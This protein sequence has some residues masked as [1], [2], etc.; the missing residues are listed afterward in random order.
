MD[1]EKAESQGDL[2]EFCK[3]YIQFKNM[4]GVGE[5]VKQTL[6][7]IFLSKIVV[8]LQNLIEHSSL[9]IF[10]TLEIYLASAI[11]RCMILYTRL[12]GV[13]PRVKNTRI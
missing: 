2:L 9:M 7:M 6:T 12:Y 1:L 11:Q 5:I 3:K 13:V 10:I 8:F 4:S